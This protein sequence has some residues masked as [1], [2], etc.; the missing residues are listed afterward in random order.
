MFSK[1]EMVMNL[2]EAA[3][4]YGDFSLVTQVY[5]DLLSENFDDTIPADEKISSCLAQNTEA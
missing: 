1:S 5:Q 2:I 3:K 4:F